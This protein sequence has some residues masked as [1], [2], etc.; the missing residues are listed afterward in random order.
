MGSI[1]IGWGG[2][3]GEEFQVKRR[4]KEHELV[5]L[6]PNIGWPAPPTHPSCVFGVV[7]AFAEVPNLQLMFDLVSV[8]AFS[9]FLALLYCDIS[10]L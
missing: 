6:P 5:L 1:G 4:F 8:R 9:R 7:L 10:D 2:G 3:G